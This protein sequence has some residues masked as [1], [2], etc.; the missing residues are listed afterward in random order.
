MSSPDGQ[1]SHGQ[2]SQHLEQYS[3]EEHK[4]D[5]DILAACHS[6]QRGL[7]DCQIGHELKGES[8]VGAQALEQKGG[9]GNLLRPVTKKNSELC[10]AGAGTWRQNLKLSRDTST[11]WR[12]AL[13]GTITCDNP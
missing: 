4:E 13:C 10:P 1:V 7:L 3:I 5:Q 8:Y 11:L 12:K 9:R 6:P 2:R